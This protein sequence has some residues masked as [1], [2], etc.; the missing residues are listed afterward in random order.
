MKNKTTIILLLLLI[1]NIFSFKSFAQVETYQVK[2]WTVF[3]KIDPITDELYIRLLNFDSNNRHT[4]NFIYTPKYPKTI[5]LEMEYLDTE[6]QFH[7]IVYR[8]DK[9]EP[10]ETNWFNGKNSKEDG[11]VKDALFFVDNPKDNLKEFIIKMMIYNKLAFAYNNINNERV[12]VVFDLSGFTK[13][14]T[15]YLD[16]LGLESL[17]DIYN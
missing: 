10:I 4:L 5:G 1:I 3:K 16:E 9:Q 2:K 11:K 17:K 13:A 14:I 6:N 12:T 8:F 7:D 15:P